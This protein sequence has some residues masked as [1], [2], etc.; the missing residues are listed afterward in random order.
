M[1]ETGVWKSLRRGWQ[2]LATGFSGIPLYIRRAVG[3]GAILLSMVLMAV[4]Q[5]DS[6]TG[7]KAE[8]GIALL[9][10]F[11]FVLLLTIASRDIR[12][13]NWDTVGVGLSLQWLF[14]ILVLRIPFG[15]AAFN[16]LSGVINNFLS[17]AKVGLEFVVGP[18]WAA[19]PIFIFTALPVIVS[20]FE[21][22]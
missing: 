18:E 1:Q 19:I 11:V 5:P 6:A 12:H 7:T 3:Y 14:A 2:Q 8:R 16:W 4:I 9:G 20:T 17:Y 22:C 15:Y 10:M 21:I 13:I